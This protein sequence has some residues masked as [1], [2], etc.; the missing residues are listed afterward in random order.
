MLALLNYPP[1]F[2]KG[3]EMIPK[4]GKL[5]TMYAMYLIIN[6][7]ACHLKHIELWQK[8]I[9]SYQIDKCLLYKIS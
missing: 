8:H 2:D 9:L 5:M 1:F 4:Y 3:G 7:C 6:A